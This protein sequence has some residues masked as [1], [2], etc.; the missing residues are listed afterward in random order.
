MDV[1][2]RVAAMDAFFA[3]VA[4]SFDKLGRDIAATFDRVGVDYNRSTS[5]AQRAETAAKTGIVSEHDAGLSSLPSYVVELG[6]RA[7]VVDVSSNAIAALPENL[8]ALVKAHKL[9]AARNALLSLPPSVCSMA[10]LRVLR[11][12]GNRLESLPARL[13]DL[14][15]LEELSLA[16][17]RIAALP[18]SVAALRKLSRLDLSRNRLATFSDDD[19]ADASGLAHLAG[20]A[21]LTEIRLD[22]NVNVTRLPA[23]W[24]GLNRLRMLSCDGAG[25]REVPG[26]LLAGCEA[27]DA[28]S[29]R[30][31]PIDVE[32]FKATDG[33]DAFEARRRKFRDK[34][35]ESG[36]MLG[37]GGLDDGLDHPAA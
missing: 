6:A 18:T 35:I 29:L 15:R 16:D 31:C 32:A 1:F 33:Y 10:S 28:L 7:R 20:C 24:G 8:G 17:N 13:G 36:V 5:A 26:R 30:G 19:G 23:G 27:L 21:S 14:A 22:G 2:A 34:Q 4:E 9:N 12:E 25:V 11:L 3:S 37:P